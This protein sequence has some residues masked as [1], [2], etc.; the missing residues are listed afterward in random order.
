MTDG[1]KLDLAC[2]NTSLGINGGYAGNIDFNK[3][4]QNDHGND[5]HFNLAT[6]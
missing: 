3:G 1:V 2:P 6:D 5:V 4:T